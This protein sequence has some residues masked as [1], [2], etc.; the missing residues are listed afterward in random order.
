MRRTRDPI[1]R[2]LEK[3]DQNGPL[4]EERP[5][6]GPCWLWTAG[7]SRHG[8]A[9]FLLSEPREI[10]AHRVAHIL[11]KGPI[12]AD[13]EVDHLCFVRHCVNPAHLEAV[14]QV[15]NMRRANL[16]RPFHHDHRGYDRG[17]RCEDCLEGMRAYGRE[18]FARQRSAFKA[19]QWD[20]KHGTNH[21]YSL[22]CRCDECSAFSKAQTLVYRRKR[23]VKPKPELRHGTTSMYTS[24]RCQCEPCLSNWRE[25]NRK[26]KARR[27]A[28]REAEQNRDA[29]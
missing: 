5:D 15:V 24:R 8:Y 3:V 29:A 22:G 17:C 19:G 20:G 9:R 14:V 25:Y 28:R 16:R 12:P 18:C 26:A 10:W 13:W 4:S 1:E 21:A 23:G 27:K 7:R 6:L 11:F 2:F